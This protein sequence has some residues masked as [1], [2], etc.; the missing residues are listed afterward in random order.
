MNYLILAV[1]VTGLLLATTGGLGLLVTRARSRMMTKK[2]ASMGTTVTIGKGQQGGSILSGD[3]IKL[4][5]GKR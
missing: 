5:G 3:Y 4:S 1:V 2:R